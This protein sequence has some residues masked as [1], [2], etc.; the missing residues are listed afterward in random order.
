MTGWLIFFGII[1][2][3]LGILMIPVHAEARYKEDFSLKIRCLFFLKFQIIPMKEKKKK[4]EKPKEEKPKTEETPK[5]PK[6]EKRKMTVEEIVDM[7]VDAV[8]KYGPGAKMIL[9][10]IRFHRIELYWRVGGEDAAECGIKYGRVC[11]WL[12]GV[13]GFFRNLMKIEKAKIRVFP[14]F[15]CEKDEI[16]GGADIE[17]NPLI[18]IIGAL[19]MAF[20]FLGDLIKSAKN[21]PK[22]GSAKPR[23]NIK[24]KESI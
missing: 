14:D 1:L 22:H 7:I 19:R 6:K 2:F 8:K 15:I 10:N 3:I 9:R 17:F 21:K 4:E 13:L 5:E 20:V 12:S 11:A 24:A 23:Q 18:V 16:Y